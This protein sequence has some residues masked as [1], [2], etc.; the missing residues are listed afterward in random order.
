[1]EV[2]G[3]HLL[4]P[5]L[6]AAGCQVVPRAGLCSSP[7]YP[8]EVTPGPSLGHPFP[9][10][11][12]I[13]AGKEGFRKSCWL[14]LGVE[15]KS[16]RTHTACHGHLLPGNWGCGGLATGEGAISSGRA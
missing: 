9:P 4:V 6:L 14:W 10:T 13:Q 16:G 15:Q 11:A 5:R 12:G 7:L 8:G 1:M 2:L 3:P